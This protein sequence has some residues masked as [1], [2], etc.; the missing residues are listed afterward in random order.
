M[1]GWQNF[2][3]YFSSRFKFS[4]Q[5][6]AFK[7]T[8]IRPIYPLI[9]AAWFGLAKEQP[10]NTL[11]GQKTEPQIAV[12]QPSE[13]TQ[14]QKE[15]D[16]RAWMGTRT[17]A[18]PLSSKY[19]E[20]V[21]L[22]K[23]GK[24]CEERLRNDPGN[25]YFD[26]EP[27]S[28]K[29]VEQYYHQANSLA[30]EIAQSDPKVIVNTLSALGNFYLNMSG[31][32]EDAEFCFK[33]MNKILI[34]DL[35]TPLS[36]LSILEIGVKLSKCY[37][38]QGKMDQFATTLNWV[39]FTTTQNLKKIEEQHKD[40]EIPESFA[41]MNLE[42]ESEIVRL[43]GNTLA[44]KGMALEMWVKAYY[45][46]DLPAADMIPIASEAV[47]VCERLYSRIDCRT[48]SLKSNK[49]LAY[50]TAKNYE[51]AVEVALEVEEDMKDFSHEMRTNPPKYVRSTR[52]ESWNR[53]MK[54]KKLHCATKPFE[55][56]FL[57]EACLI[58][59]IIAKINRSSSTDVEFAGWRQRRHL[60]QQQ[61]N[62][63]KILA[64]RTQDNKL[65]KYVYDQLSNRRVS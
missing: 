49:A 18:D 13:Y 44:L 9:G 33:A 14:K 63:A 45:E 27:V 52:L 24:V 21:Q 5:Q 1:R 2:R 43:Y 54:S 37:F 30:K 23:K 65:M 42:N 34:T 29:R 56:L 55:D 4:N 59:T 39:E 10:D 16:E 7:R 26:G 11:Q 48:I 17:A 36:E 46:R 35:K 38:I 19:P 28:L 57:S 64:E 51:K 58:W 25:A 62:H 47:V 12:Q 15:N 6:N 60:A 40:A 41:G 50:V 31:L 53:A 32:A 20:I 8:S 22:L 61:F 3:F